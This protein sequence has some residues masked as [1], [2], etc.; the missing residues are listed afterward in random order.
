MAN[1]KKNERFIPAKNYIIAGFIVV[2]VVL[3]TWYG[4]AWYNVYKENRVSTSYLVKNNII[5]KE[6][7]DLNEAKDVFAEAP[8]TYFVYVSYTG[9]DE[10]YQMEKNIRNLIREYKLN[11]EIYY[12]NVTDI[13]NDKNL[14]SKINKTLGLDKNKISTIPTF[15]YFNGGEVPK[16]GIIKPI[17]GKTMTINDFQK[18]LDVNS[19]VKE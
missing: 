18:F 3:L 4:F 10:I 17:D 7:T 2:V 12:L 1:I 13:K 19:I 8:E 16:S 5:T 9:D 11:E 14:I 6:I 15:V